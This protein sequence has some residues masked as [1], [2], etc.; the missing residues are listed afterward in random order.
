VTDLYEWSF[1]GHDTEC[2]VNVERFGPNHS[3]RAF[4][5]ASGSVAAIGPGYEREL[6]TYDTRVLVE[7][8]N[9]LLDAARVMRENRK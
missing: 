4:V 8:G 2:Y 6:Q 7:F 9:A 5:G 3:P 1:V